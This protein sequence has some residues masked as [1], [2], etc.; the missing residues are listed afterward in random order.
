M[1][2]RQHLDCY[3]GA[4]LAC[5]RGGSPCSNGDMQGGER[6]QGRANTGMER[7]AC[8]TITKVSVL[9]FL[10]RK[11]NLSLSLAW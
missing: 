11:L 9:M 6:K 10:K 3:A 2:R 7:M 1:L 5:L 8:L 4:L